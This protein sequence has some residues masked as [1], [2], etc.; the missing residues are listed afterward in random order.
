V[1]AVL[2]AWSE[3][4]LASASDMTAVA[5]LMR[6]APKPYDWLAGTGAD[7][8][9]VP[10]FVWGTT[11]YMDTVDASGEVSHPNILDMF[12]RCRSAGLGGAVVL[13]CVVSA[14]CLFGPAQRH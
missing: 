1:C 7:G 14:V 6:A 4:L 13:K 12:E 11:A 8:K 10:P 9:M 5:V 2:Y 3:R